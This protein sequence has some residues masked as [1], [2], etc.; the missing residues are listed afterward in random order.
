MTTST[1]TKNYYHV[2]DLQIPRSKQDARGVTPDAVKK[3]YRKRLL[4]VH[5]DKVSRSKSTPV[6]EN[7]V[8]SGARE[9]ESGGAASIE[10]ERERDKGGKDGMSYTVDDVKEAFRILGDAGEKSRYD[11][12]LFNPSHNNT[13]LLHPLQHNTTIPH[14][15][16]P[17]PDFLLGLEVLDLEDFREGGA[18][19]GHDEVSGG[20]GDGEE[21]MKW[22]R[23]C[24]C[25]DDEGF[26][27]TEEELDGAMERGEGEVLVGCG[28]CSLWV[29]V[30]FGVLEGEG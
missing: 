25:G 5:P 17:S 11:T 1:Y 29:R 19:G 2:L 24:R 9:E 10:T 15:T 22:T 27:I 26:V 3:A 18:G 14:S 30:G 12:W 23:A 28:G 8:A 7:G 4:G 6:N 21:E 13:H 20:N 16:G